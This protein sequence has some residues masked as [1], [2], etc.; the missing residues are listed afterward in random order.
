MNL[1]RYLQIF[2][3][4]QIDGEIL[5]QCDENV[6]E[7]ELGISNT[8]HRARLMKIITGKVSASGILKG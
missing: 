4:E 8:I 6:L 3:N 7:H 1:S 5:S 2:I